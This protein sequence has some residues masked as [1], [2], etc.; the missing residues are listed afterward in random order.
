M[1]SPQLLFSFN[2]RKA[3]RE[4]FNAFPQT[5]RTVL[6]ALILICA[7]VFGLIPR[8][9]LRLAILNVPKPMSWTFF[10]FLIPVLMPSITALTD[11]SAEALLTSL[12]RSFCTATTSSA[13]FIT[14]MC[15]VSGE[16]CLQWS[17]IEIPKR[18]S[19]C[20]LSFFIFFLKINYFLAM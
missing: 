10:F 9:A 14:V 8:R 6:D 19:L 3:Y 11:F 7:P 15:V 17:P 5:K 4:V 16:L 20:Q 18:V 12:P 13:L 2:R 1:S